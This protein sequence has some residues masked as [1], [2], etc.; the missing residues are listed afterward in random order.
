LHRSAVNSQVRASRLL[1]VNALSRCIFKKP[2]SA[3][4]LR[5]FLDS[6]VLLCG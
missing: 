3:N 2:R 4:S 6:G 5:L 1:T